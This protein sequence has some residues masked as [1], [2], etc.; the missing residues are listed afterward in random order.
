MEVAE[1]LSWE[2]G[3]EEGLVKRGWEGARRGGSD[4]HDGGD[5]GCMG[6]ES[7]DIELKM[8][9]FALFGASAQYDWFQLLLSQRR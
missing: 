5:E 1:G 7:Q 8:H 6:L 4:D 3:F 2:G 9:F